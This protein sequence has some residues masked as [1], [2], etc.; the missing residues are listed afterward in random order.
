MAGD[1]RFVTVTITEFPTEDEN[2]F[3]IA[4]ENLCAHVERT[5]TDLIV[6][7]EL[8]FHKWLFA[9]AEYNEAAWNWACSEHKR[10]M[11]SFLALLSAR[12][13]NPNVYVSTTRPVQSGDQRLNIGAVWS[14]STGLQDVHAKALLPNDD[15]TWEANWYHSGPR[16]V[17]SAT[18]DI[19]GIPLRIGFQIC[20]E[21]WFTDI[22][23]ALAHDGVDLIIAPRATGRSSVPKW[24]I[25]L[26]A[27][28]IMSGAFVAS[29]NRSTPGNEEFGGAGMLVTP[30]GVLMG[31]T[32]SD[33]PYLTHTVDIAVAQRAKTTYPRNVSGF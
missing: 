3:V 25:G 26:Q 32:T 10:K 19:G 5:F 13:V 20:T 33:S 9:E 1:S 18:I 27:A 8:A 15:G 2:A 29:S 24:Q 14:D 7:P 6:L 17:D 23:R 11:E 30:D 28:A 31:T 4:W 22:S 12:S 16:D 21:I